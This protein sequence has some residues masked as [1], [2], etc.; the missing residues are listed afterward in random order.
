MMFRRADE[1]EEEAQ[2][3]LDLVERQGKRLAALV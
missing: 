2:R 3:L 1:A